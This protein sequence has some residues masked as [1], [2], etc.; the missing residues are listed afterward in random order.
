MLVA[1]L[2]GGEREKKTK[3]G[4]ENPLD[5][6]M[7]T[8][9]GKRE[10]KARPFKKRKVLYSKKGGYLVRDPGGNASCF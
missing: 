2:L 3:E 8:E 4:E 10:G 9:G 1:G 7:K 6:I 5:W